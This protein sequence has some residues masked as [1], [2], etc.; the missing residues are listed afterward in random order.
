M[1]SQLPAG[2]VPGE[3]ETEEAL[4]ATAGIH[5]TSVALRKDQEDSSRVRGGQKRKMSEPDHERGMYQ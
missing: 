1:E 3:V 5:D 4:G 2:P